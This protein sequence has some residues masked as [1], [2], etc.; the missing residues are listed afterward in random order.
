MKGTVEQRIA[1]SLFRRR[2]AWYEQ[3]VEE[4]RQA[5]RE[6]FRPSHCPHGTN[7]HVDYDPICGN[8]EAPEMY[9]GTGYYSIDRDVTRR[10]ALDTAK[11]RV[12]VARKMKDDA[13]FMYEG[14]VITFDEMLAIHHTIV[15]KYLTP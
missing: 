7:L 13:G 11:T 5:Q 2:V 14:G 9:D 1:I 6:G 15:D 4:K 8:C 10:W 12:K 3:W